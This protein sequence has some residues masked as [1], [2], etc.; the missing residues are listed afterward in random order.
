[1]D[2]AVAGERVIR[3]RRLQARGELAPGAYDL[4]IDGMRAPRVVWSCAADPARLLVAQV[5]DLHVGSGARAA[6]RLA[7]ILDEVARARPDLVLVTGDVVNNA[8]RA[9]QFERA[10]EILSALEAPTFVVPGNHDHGFGLRALATS[11]G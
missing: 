5:T 3:R 10:R 2:L 6:R 1:T 9:T 8:D 4:V 7:H 11:V